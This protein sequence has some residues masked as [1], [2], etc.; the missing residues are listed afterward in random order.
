MEFI[1]GVL[2]TGTKQ[3]DAFTNMGNP[4]MVGPP[5]VDMGAYEYL[6]A[7]I[8]SSGAVDLRDFSE[9]ALQWLKT[10]CGRCGG[11]NMTCD[12][13]VDWNDLRVLTDWWLAGK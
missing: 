1:Q 13:N 9:F 2:P 8:D 6:P 4:G 7:D 3:M 11:A 10:G 5:V 12:G